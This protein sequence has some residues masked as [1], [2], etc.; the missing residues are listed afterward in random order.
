[1]KIQSSE[2]V[3]QF[4]DNEDLYKRLNKSLERK[5]SSKEAEIESI[6]KLYDKKIETA[7]ID[8]EEKYLQNLERNQIRMNDETNLFQTKISEYENKLLKA[9]EATQNEEERLKNHE[10][11]RIKELKNHSEENYQDQYLKA[12]DF[13]SE[14]QTKTQ[15]DIKEMATNAKFQKLDLENNSKFEINA[16]AQNYNNSIAVNEKEF[17]NSIETN[18]RAHQTEMLRQKDDLKKIMTE[19]NE[20]HKRLSLEKNRVNGDQLIYQDKHQKEMLKQRDQ[21]FKARYDLIVKEHETILTDLTTKLNSDVKKMIESTTSEKKL[22]S[23]RMEDPFYRIEKL[24]PK[25]TEN[26][27]VVFISMPIAEYEK[28]N[29]F[30]STQGRQIKMTLSRKYSEANVAV[31]GSR[32]KSTRNELFSKEFTSKDILDQREI[33]RNYAD[34]IL[35]FKIKKA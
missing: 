2:I 15:D 30:L 8:G 27:K 28:E 21:D 33:S 14:I 31:D 19:D 13:Q 1:M 26:E 10:D 20:K 18:I 16:L 34:G 25:M 23:D 4:K 24:M 32:N 22:I 3:N 7:K 35:T 9:R 6:D 11:E 12:K 17:R 29:V 5:I